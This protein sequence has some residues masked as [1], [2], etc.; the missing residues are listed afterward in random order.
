MIYIYIGTKIYIS[1]Y[2]LETEYHTLH[3]FNILPLRTNIVS[4]HKT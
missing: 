1:S 3:L 4:I 2:D